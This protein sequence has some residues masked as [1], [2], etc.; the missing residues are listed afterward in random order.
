MQKRECVQRLNM[1]V[2]LI[3]Q[4]HK[5]NNLGG[6]ILPVDAPHCHCRCLGINEHPPQ[7]GLF[8]LLLLSLS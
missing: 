6:L 3:V 8:L 7:L 1:S 5:I 4:D 2:L